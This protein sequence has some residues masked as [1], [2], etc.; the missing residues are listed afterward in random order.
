MDMGVPVVTDI[1]A[2]KML[3]TALN[4]PTVWGSLPSEL[5]NPSVDCFTK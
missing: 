5:V 3:A 2:A 1:K 4:L